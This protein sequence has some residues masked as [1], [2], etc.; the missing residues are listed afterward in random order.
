MRA[1]SRKIAWARTVAVVVPSPAVSE[2]LEA[3]SL[4]IC[5]PRLANLS[6]SSISL[7][8]V[9][10]SLVTVGAPQDFSMTTLRPRGP[11]VAFTV[12]ASA[13]TPARMR[14]RPAS[15]NRISL[16]AMGDSL[17]LDDA[18]DVVLAQDE[19]IDAVDLDLV[20]AVLAEQDPVALLDGQRAHRPLVIR[21]SVTDGDNLCLGRL[22]LG[23]VGDDDPPLGLLFLGDATDQH[24]ILQ[25]TNFHL[26]PPETVFE[27]L[28]A[29]RDSKL[30]LTGSECQ[31]GTLAANPSESTVWPNRLASRNFVCQRNVCS[32]IWNHST[33]LDFAICS[34]K[35]EVWTL[36]AT[37][38]GSF[39]TRSTARSGTRGCHR[40]PWSST[41][42]SSCC[43]A[44]PPTASRTGRS[45]CG[46]WPR[47]RPR[48]PRDAGSC[49][50]SATPRSTSRAS[51]ASTWRAARSTSTTTSAW[52]GRRT[53]SSP[54]EGPGGPVTLSARCSAS[55]RSTSSAS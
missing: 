7:A 29:A 24:A 41:T 21:L 4:T 9:T 19:V 42:S 1:P 46:C 45:R 30:A 44:T 22:L 15:S 26:T 28:R 55:W 3:T 54:A 27:R 34:R 36:R 20:A 14:E 12:S 2:V 37:S 40:G 8:T 49:A 17:F 31:R 53:A 43:R 52:A 18:E 33:I 11:S 50:T 13:L 39:T 25:R 32:S 5:A 16:A 10:P 38:R 6:S 47:P 23:G 48:C 35:A 51:G